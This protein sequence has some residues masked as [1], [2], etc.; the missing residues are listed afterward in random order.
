MGALP[1]FLLWVYLSW[2]VFLLGA[3]LTAILNDPRAALAADDEGASGPWGRLRAA[4]AVARRFG[5]AAASRPAGLGELAA[6]A[7]LSET[8]ARRLL[9]QL[10]AAGVVIATASSDS[11]QETLYVLARAPECL[12]LLDVLGLFPA[13]N[14]SAD[15]AG[16]P[17][18]AAALQTARSRTAKA[19]GEL[20]LADVL[21]T[22]EP[23]A[24]R[25]A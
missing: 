13:A 14:P 22:T 17:A 21:K 15:V 10:A 24:E 20:T 6:L 4:L 8:D 9:D 25:Q 5:D 3:Q 18:V 16:D 1:L 23:D 19:M 11:P 12:P 2:A 7:G